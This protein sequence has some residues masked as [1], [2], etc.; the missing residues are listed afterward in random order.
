MTSSNKCLIILFLLFFVI[1]ETYAQAPA[2]DECSGAIALPVNNDNS[3]T[4]NYN[5][6]LGYATQSAPPCAATGY[7]AKDAWYKFT[8][9]ATT[10]NITL[11]P[12]SF[13]DYIF[14]V[15]S[16]SC[17]GLVSM[18]CVN[19]TGLGEKEATVVNNLTIGNTYYIRVYNRYGDATINRTFNISIN[20]S[21]TTI[22]NDECSG[23]ID[24]ATDGSTFNNVYT[25]IG[26]TLSMPGCSGTAYN[27]IWFRFTATSTRH[28]VKAYNTNDYPMVIQVFQGSCGSLTPI[29]CFDYPNNVADL[30]N[31]TPGTVYYY[32][33]YLKGSTVST[34]I[35]TYVVEPIPS[36]PILTANVSQCAKDTLEVSVNGIT[37]GNIVAGYANGRIMNYEAQR[38]ILWL[39]PNTAGTYT[40][41]AVQKKPDLITISDTAT[42]N[43]IIYAAMLPGKTTSVARQCTNAKFNVSV[44][45]D[46]NT[47]PS[48][49]I[50][51]LYEIAANGAFTIVG[52]QTYTGSSLN[53]ERTG[54]I[55][56]MNKYF[57]VCVPPAGSACN[58]SSHTDT[59]V[60][61]IEALPVPIA[62]SQK[63]SILRV[64]Q[65]DSALAY[66]WQWQSAN[67]DWTN[68][69]G[70]T[71]VI[72]F[73]HKAGVYRVE[74]LK[75]FCTQIS[76]E[77]QVSDKLNIN[78]F[79]NPAQEKITINPLPDEDAWKTLTIIN[80][81]GE[82]AKSV[83]NIENQNQVSIDVR[84]L[85]SGVY[86]V[87][88][89][90][91]SGQKKYFKFVK[92]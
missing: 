73:V 18:A 49:T 31:L 32:R 69:A 64:D 78:L 29:L 54:T 76:N 6:A 21:T 35:N 19:S 89:Q 26:A 43:I 38:K 81:K 16:G 50:V 30:T 87:V 84:A 61:I 36:K 7:E 70:A 17:G 72:Y 88:L 67:G 59:A 57:A 63:G 2:N 75:S 5:G 91:N 1:S 14:Q 90:G 25:N 62:I 23:A 55:A 48:N 92:L 4:L 41:K 44:T 74:N 11:T 53:W 85:P 80:T 8:A 42:I 15:Y 82:Q 51:T 66:Q 45:P 79:P 24:I 28:Q 40:I 9:T 46:G 39:F 37:S 33:L 10:H 83:L 60:T 86:I 77:I 56:G 71:G 20:A 12:I 47:T 68:I 3:N 58:Y 27:D 52:T 34:N 65:P 22:P 13:D